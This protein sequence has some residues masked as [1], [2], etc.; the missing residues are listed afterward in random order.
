MVAKILPNACAN[1]SLR[2]S[3]FF[4]ARSTGDRRSANLYGRL[5]QPPIS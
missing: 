3:H 2:R 4:R 1:R 5:D